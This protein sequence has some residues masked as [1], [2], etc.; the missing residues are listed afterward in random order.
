M[1]GLKILAHKG[2]THDS[3]INEHEGNEKGHLI[4]STL[5]TSNYVV[6][7]P[8]S[9]LLALKPVEPTKD[10]PENKALHELQVTSFPNG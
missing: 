4:L 3:G 1:I 10:N 6:I 5:F 8:F 9:P 7:C 2:S